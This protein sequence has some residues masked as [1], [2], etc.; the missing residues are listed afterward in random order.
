MLNHIII[1]TNLT[2]KQY[3]YLHISMIIYKNSYKS[4]YSKSSFV[5]S[6]RNITFNYN[7]SDSKYLIAI[8]KSGPMSLTRNKATMIL[9]WPWICVSMTLKQV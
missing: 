6:N 7:R 1:T 8:Y 4:M 5:N 3:K 9:K 2:V